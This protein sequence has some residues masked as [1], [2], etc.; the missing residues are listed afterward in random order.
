[1]KKTLCMLLTAAMLLAAAGCA[2]KDENPDTNDQNDGKNNEQTTDDTQYSLPDLVLTDYD[3]K[4]V[5][6][7]GG[8]DISASLYRYYLLNLRSQYDGGNSAMW[9]NNEMSD[10]V[11]QQVVS[12]LKE[13]AA[14]EVMA[15]NLSVTVSDDDKKALDNYIAQVIAE[16]NKDENTSYA[17]ELEAANMTDAMFRDLQDNS[18]IQSQIYVSKYQGTATDEQILDY[19]HQ[20]YVRVKHILIKTVDLDDE[21]KAEARK[22]ADNVL[23]RAKNGENFEDLVKEFSED[24]MDPDTGYYF[25][26]GQMVQEFEDKSFDLAEGEISDIVESKY[27]YHIIK[28]YAMDDDYILSDET[29]RSAA[30]DSICEEVFRTA[31]SEVADTLEVVYADDFEATREKILLDNEAK[32]NASD[33]NAENTADADNADTPDAS[34]EGTEK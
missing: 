12:Y 34:D 17:A 6:T 5:M 23:E 10:Y 18:L 1:M 9:D 13:Y 7:I 15:D 25:T 8:K 19:V 21:Q 28:K 27:G 33:E 32:N 22:R 24:G 16:I 29:L 31:L 26:T 30:E 2:K 4:T 14:A 11:E 20:N 3:Q